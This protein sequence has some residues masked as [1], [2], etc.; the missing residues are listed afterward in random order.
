M[1]KEWNYCEKLFL[2]NLGCSTSR[3]VDLHAEAGINQRWRLRKIGGKEKTFSIEAVAATECRAETSLGC[4]ESGGNH[5]E[6]HWDDYSGRQ[7][8]KINWFPDYVKAKQITK[9]TG[10]WVAFASGSEGISAELTTSVSSETGKSMSKES[11]NEF[12]VSTSAEFEFSGWFT[13]MTLGVETSFS[14]SATEAQETSSSLSGGT[15]DTCQAS[16]SG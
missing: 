3:T 11:T 14:T 13:G 16:C 4:T 12:S 8:V 10:E 5:V 15:D 9:I 7:H 1:W 2:S 6:L